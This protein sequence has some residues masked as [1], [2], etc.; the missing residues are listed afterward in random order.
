MT[1]YG[2]LNGTADCV[3][4]ALRWTEVSSMNEVHLWQHQITTGCN[5]PRLGSILLRLEEGI[6]SGCCH[7]PSLRLSSTALQLR[8][9]L[10]QVEVKYYLNV[11]SEIK[12]LRPRVSKLKKLGCSGPKKW[13]K[14]PNLKILDFVGWCDG[15]YW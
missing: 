13:A 4:T 5:G 14:D 8:K 9:Y 6:F 3:M 2:D 15:M 12:E 11:D 7:C 1:I 10:L